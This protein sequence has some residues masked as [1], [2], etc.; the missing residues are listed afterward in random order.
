M[1][2]TQITDDIRHPVKI[3]LFLLPLNLPDN[4]NHDPTVRISPGNKSLRSQGSVGPLESWRK[5]FFKQNQHQW[6]TAA[7]D[8]VECL[9]T[10]L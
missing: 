3:W 7:P 6:D 2:T 4:G 8:K 9:M 1:T 5:P 10:P